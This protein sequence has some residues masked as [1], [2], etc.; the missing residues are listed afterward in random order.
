MA[1]V[2]FDFVSTSSSD[3]SLEV[4][5]SLL[6]SL[7]AFFFSLLAAAL[8]CCGRK[9]LTNGFFSVVGVLLLLAVT[10]L[11]AGVARERAGLS[12]ARELLGTAAAAAELV[13]LSVDAVESLLPERVVFLTAAT[14]ADTGA[15]D[16]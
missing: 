2:D 15:L 16:C 13:E 12:R 9:R 14:C 4:S 5:S 3:S 10:A 8:L 11:L 7:S 1:A 6:D